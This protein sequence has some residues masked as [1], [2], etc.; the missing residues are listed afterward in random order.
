MLQRDGG[1]LLVVACIDVRL[2][3]FVSLL[4]VYAAKRS[5]M[6]TVAESQGVNTK[7]RKIKKLA[8]QL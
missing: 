3:L 5:A 6:L 8:K 7:D 2:P 1:V 4:Q